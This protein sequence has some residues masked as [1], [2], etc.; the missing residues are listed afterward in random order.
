M[1]EKDGRLSASGFL[2]CGKEYILA[3]E[4][5]ERVAVDSGQSVHR[6]SSNKSNGGGIWRR[7]SDPGP[8]SQ[9]PDW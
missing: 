2:D 3:M 8:I 7:R 5:N 4:E 6:S 9:P 1:L